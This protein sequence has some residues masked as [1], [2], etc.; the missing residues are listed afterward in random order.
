MKQ[1][2]TLNEP[3]ARSY[4]RQLIHGLRHLHQSNIVHRDLKLGNMLLTEDMTIKICDFGLASPFK[5]DAKV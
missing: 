3:E 2:K 4:L 5:P 1:R